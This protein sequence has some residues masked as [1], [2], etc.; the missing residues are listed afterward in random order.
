MIQNLV[1]QNL[2]DVPHDDMANSEFKCE[3]PNCDKQYRHED[4]K[5]AWNLLDLHVR[6]V[7]PNI[8]GAAVAAGNGPVVAPKLKIQ[9][10]TISERET[11]SRW[12]T[13]QY[14]WSNYKL[15][16]GLNTREKIVMEL[17][18]CCD[19]KLGQKLLRD[20]EANHDTET[21]DEFLKQ[22][23]KFVVITKSINAHRSE[24]GKL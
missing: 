13:F 7:H 10:P 8:R 11:E 9:R 12:E 21:E 16:N 20:P 15:Y 23:K 3:E 5:M 2:G 17:K 4:A 1:I 24:F 19:A 14:E 6:T 18:Q 22:V